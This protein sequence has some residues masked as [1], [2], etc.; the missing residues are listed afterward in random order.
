MTIDV[1]SD[2]ACPWCYIGE[3]RLF[4]ALARRPDLDVQPRWR[5]F[6]LQPD[7]PATGLPW[8]AFAER[9]FGG[10]DRARAGFRHVERAAAADGIAFD[11][12]GIATA[13]N[14]ADA[15]RLVLFAREH[16]REWAMADMLFKGYFAEGRD[17]GAEEDLIAITEQSG[18]DAEAAAAWLAS[19]AGHDA[20]R[21]SQAFAQR[22]GITGV[23][24]TIIDGRLGLSGAQP[25]EAFAQALDQAATA[26]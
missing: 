16:D 13:A 8:R 22:L 2:I 10:W 25:V 7:L 5:P 19:D 26:T 23:P 12:E 21:E 18:L 11:F 4:A 6:Q 9:K 24:F 3:K 20:V 1:F 15:H 17:L 14:T